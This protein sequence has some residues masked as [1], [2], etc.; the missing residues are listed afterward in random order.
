ML[1][2]A[3]AT[4]FAT[5]VEPFVSPSGFHPMLR[6]S[7]LV[8]PE[9]SAVLKP[10]APSSDDN[11]LRAASSMVKVSLKLEPPN[12]LADTSTSLPPAPLL[13]T[14]IAATPSYPATLLPIVAL[15]PFEEYL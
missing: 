14:P 15:I 10:P 12:E 3:S 4:P 13:V 1:F 7:A 9:K 11:V 8:R 6:F 5:A 2:T